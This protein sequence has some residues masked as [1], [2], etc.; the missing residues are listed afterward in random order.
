[1]TFVKGDILVGTNR[2]FEKAYHPIVYI[3]GPQTAPLAVV[4][5]RS[6]DFP[7]N[8]SLQHI[9]DSKGGNVQYFV[10]HLIEKMPDWSPY[11]K[12][13]KLHSDDLKLIE[14]SIKDSNPMTWQ[15]YEDYTKGKKCPDHP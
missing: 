10:A 6:R 11:V 9:Y 5:T 13:G 12:V 14:S 7:C 1:M 2:A 3:H 15:Q 4:L 8:K